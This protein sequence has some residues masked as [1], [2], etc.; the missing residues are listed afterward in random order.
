[1]LLNEG[2]LKSS[3]PVKDPHP[4]GTHKT[5]TVPLR[6]MESCSG[7]GME[8]ECRQENRQA[9]WQIE[10]KVTAWGRKA[11]VSRAAVTDNQCSQHVWIQ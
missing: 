6:R 8:N 2:L 9:D 10:K 3:R 4:T 7:G 1:M 11:G 5:Q